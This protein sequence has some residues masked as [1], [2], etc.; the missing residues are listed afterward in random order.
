MREYEQKS[1]D[2][3]FGVQS[4]LQFIRAT[5]ALLGVIAMIIGLVYAT[6][7]FT[8][9]SNVLNNPDS[10]SAYLDKWI[11]AV[12][13]EDLRIVVNG[14]QYDC[15]I[16]IAVLIIGSGLIL[17]AWMSMAFILTGAKTVSWTLGDR[18]AVKKM[19][20]HAFGPTRK[21]GADSSVGNPPQKNEV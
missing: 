17:L 13:G 10:V 19:L 16:I 11:A 14:M 5:G 7:I 1:G 3:S 21:P 15:A 2:E 4:V 18:A 8:M 20:T 6:R 12:G 9:V